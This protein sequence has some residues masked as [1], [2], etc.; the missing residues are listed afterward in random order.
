M[1]Q[2]R[3]TPGIEIE[4][5]G[6]IRPAVLADLPHLLRLEQEGF[7]Q[8]HY[9]SRQYRYYLQRPSN[10]SLF[11]Y[12]HRESLVIGSAIM[13]WRKKS[14][15]GHLYSIVTSPSHREMGL[16]SLLLA[17]CEREALIKGCDR[18]F[19][20]VRRSNATAVTFYERRGYAITKTV[21]GYYDGDDALQML[22][23]LPVA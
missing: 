5:R 22:K 20:E 21:N 3:L 7:A 16:G 2:A 6:I 19:L 1:P 18:I 10:F 23:Q 9:S 17:A 8:D 13:G 11:V 4:S 12:E 15:I 14:R